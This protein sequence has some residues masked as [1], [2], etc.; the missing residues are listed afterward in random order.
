LNTKQRWLAIT[1]FGLIALILTMKAPAPEDETLARKAG[2]RPAVVENRTT[3]QPAN[4]Q[5]LALDKLQA[6][7][8][9]KFDKGDL[10]QSKTWYVPPPPP[11]KQKYVESSPPEPPPPPTAPPLPFNYM[12]SYQEPGAKLVIYLARGDRLYAVSPGDTIEGTYKIEGAN[13]GQLAIM[14]L[15][16][17]IRQN[18]RI[19]DR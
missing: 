15:P 16:L 9:A 4:T 18:L 7:H 3:N 17:N 8:M 11:P 6:R 2:V 13:G 5:D 14:Y 19:G 12:G 10:F 1:A